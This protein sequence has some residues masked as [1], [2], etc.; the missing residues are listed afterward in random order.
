MY[1]TLALITIVLSAFFSGIEIAFVSSNKLQLELDKGSE[2]ISSKVIA[3]FS[4]NESNF[5][6]TM[7][8][9]NNISLVVYGIVMTKILSP[10]LDSFQ[11]NS[12]LLLFVQTVISTSIILV[13]AEFLP[14]S[15]FK[16]YPNTTLRFFSFP[17]FCFFI[18]FSPFAWLFIQVSKLIVKLFFGQTLTENKQFFNKTDLD[19]YLDHINSNNTQDS[20][21]VEVEMLQNTL[22]LSEKKV[23]EC[24]IPR[25]EIIAMNINSTINDLKDKFIETK[26]SKILIYKNNIDSIIGYVHSSDLFRNPRN[27]RSLLLPLP[28]VPE[29]MS[30]MQL[31][32]DFIDENKGVALV[33]DEFGGTSGMLTIEDVTEEIVGEIDD[34][35]DT[36]IKSVDKINDGEYSI[37]ARL[38][39]ISI[40]KDFDLNLPE[41]DEYETIAGLVLHYLENIPSVGD[42]IDLEDYRITINEVDDRSVIK[43]HLLVKS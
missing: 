8:I 1:L 14:K 13:T 15:I 36:N 10:Y 22:D 25:T 32:S 21:S 38:D 42:V 7:L 39:V 16:I 9:G 37:L 26:L 2:N 17:I 4:K 43:V 29:T 3:F 33:V 23:R 20:A 31:L 19:D 24:M 30:A 41:S 40:N 27:I 5:I 35:Y 28:F 18:L 11:L 34:E 6:T 12:Y